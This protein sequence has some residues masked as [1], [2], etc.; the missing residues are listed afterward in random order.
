M[1]SASFCTAPNSAVIVC[2]FATTSWLATVTWLPIVSTVDSDGRYTSEPA[3]PSGSV[4][5]SVR[6]VAEPSGR[7][8]SA[9]NTTRSPAS[10]VAPV[11][12]GSVEFTMDS[13]TVGDAVVTEA[14][15]FSH[16]SR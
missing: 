11:V 4:I 6:F 1:L 13:V 9:C 2:P 3:A 14:V 7:S 5:T 12:Y 8:I 10:T 16:A 15:L